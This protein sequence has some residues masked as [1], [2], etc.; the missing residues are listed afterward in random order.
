MT[1]VTVQKNVQEQRK[2]VKQGAG[3]MRLGRVF[4]MVGRQGFEPG[5]N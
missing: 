3:E 1:D 4:C 5:T 2:K